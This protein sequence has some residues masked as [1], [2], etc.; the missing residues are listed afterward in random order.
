MSFRLD[1]IRDL[2]QM[3]LIATPTSLSICFEID[4][5]FSY[6]IILEEIEAEI[7]I[8]AFF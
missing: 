6:P 5:F 2:L 1:V 8:G 4:F 3:Q 7:G